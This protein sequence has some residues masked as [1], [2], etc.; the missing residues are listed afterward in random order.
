[1][2][3][4]AIEADVECANPPFESAVRTATFWLPP[5]P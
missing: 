1:V 4:E 5:D 3:V 2:P